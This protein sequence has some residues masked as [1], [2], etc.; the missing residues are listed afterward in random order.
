MDSFLAPA[1]PFIQRQTHHD[2]RENGHERHAHAALR[3]P[4]LQELLVRLEARLEPRPPVRRR[5]H[6]GLGPRRPHR[7]GV[8]LLQR[9]HRD[10]LLGLLQ[11]ARDHAQPLGEDPAQR[12]AVVAVGGVRLRRGRAQRIGSGC[13]APAGRRRRGLRIR[14]ARSGGDPGSGSGIAGARGRAV[15]HHDDVAVVVVVAV[16]LV[17]AQPLVAGAPLAR[18]PPKR[19]RQRAE[20][21]ERVGGRRAHGRL[22][23]RARP[24]P[25]EVVRRARRDGRRRGVDRQ[26]RRPAQAAGQRGRRQGRRRVA[27]RGHPPGGG[28]AGA[29]AGGEQPR[30]VGRRPAVQRERVRR[31]RPLLVGARGRQL[32]VLLRA[33]PPRSSPAG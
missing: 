18:Q 11:D 20:R 31:K 5:Q 24:Q 7:R 16:E 13:R 21:A 17:A 22:D 6:H 2:A 29:A 27:V 23:R 30:V 12:K 28:A 14:R 4:P 19:G 32:Q 1:S 26:R 9:R 15:H 10:D 8:L 3:Q 25:R 33:L